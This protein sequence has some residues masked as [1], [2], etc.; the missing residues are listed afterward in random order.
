M[1]TYTCLMNITER[2]TFHKL[3]IKQSW[4]TAASQLKEIIS[5]DMLKVMF[6]NMHKIASVRFSIP[7]SIQTSF[8]SNSLSDCSLS[9]GTR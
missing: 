7:V 9:E 8:W 6:L 1:K 4:D 5:D 2:K 3:L